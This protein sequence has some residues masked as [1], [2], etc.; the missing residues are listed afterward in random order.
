MRHFEQFSNN[1]NSVV[2]EKVV[3][4]RKKKKDLMKSGHH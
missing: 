1:V 4:E 3:N 2:L